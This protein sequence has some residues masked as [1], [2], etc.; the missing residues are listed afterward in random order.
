MLEEGRWKKQEQIQLVALD[1]GT[2]DGTEFRLGNEA[3]QPQGVIAQLTDIP[4]R[5]LPPFATVTFTQVG[6]SPEE[7]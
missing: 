2:E 4:S 5:E 1:A 3:T 7:D 6:Y